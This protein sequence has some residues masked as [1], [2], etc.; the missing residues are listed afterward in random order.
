MKPYGHGTLHKG[1]VVKTYNKCVIMGR[2]EIRY[3]K[4]VSSRAGRRLGRL[5]IRRTPDD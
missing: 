5:A 2:G 1:Q 4:H 3:L